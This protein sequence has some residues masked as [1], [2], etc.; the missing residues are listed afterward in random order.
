[1]L[2]SSNRANDANVAF[3]G[4]AERSRS[5]VSATLKRL[6][7]RRGEGDG[8]AARRDCRLYRIRGTDGRAG[9]DSAVT[10]IIAET[11]SIFPRPA[12]PTRLMMP[13]CATPMR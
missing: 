4:A 6:R 7:E 12:C 5:A 13:I 3:D 1:M 8:A 11:R 10:A 2:K 9:A